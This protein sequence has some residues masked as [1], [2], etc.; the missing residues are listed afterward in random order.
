MKPEKIMTRKE[1][2]A[3]IEEHSN[4]QLMCGTLDSQAHMLA[5]EALKQPEIIMCKDCKFSKDPSGAWDRRCSFFGVVADDFFCKNGKRK[6]E[7]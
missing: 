1:A 2:I 7:T 6:E 5:L 4:P 3:W